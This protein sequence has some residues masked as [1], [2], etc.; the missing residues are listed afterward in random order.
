[1]NY[2]F[3]VKFKDFK[4]VEKITKERLSD[5]STPPCSLD[6]IEHVD[7][8][9]EYHAIELEDGD[10]ELYD[11]FNDFVII[12]DTKMVNKVEKI[13]HKDYCTNPSHTETMFSE[14][15][16]LCLSICPICGKETLD[17]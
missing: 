16:N 11:D 1:M 17:V 15:G 12:V 4:T 7:Y 2:D 6:D 14:E 13:A 5:G 8:S 9:Y 10:L 3:D